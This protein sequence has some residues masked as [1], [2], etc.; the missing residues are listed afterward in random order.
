M[1]QKIRNT[2]NND[3]VYAG[4]NVPIIKQ[5][6]LKLLTISKNSI[7]ILILSKLIQQIKIKNTNAASTKPTM[8]HPLTTPEMAAIPPSM[9]IVNTMPRQNINLDKYL[10]IYIYTTDNT[11]DNENIN[12]IILQ[13]FIN[14]YFI[15]VKGLFSTTRLLGMLG[16]RIAD[17]VTR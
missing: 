15:T 2:I 12:K 14:S 1:N 6:F 10:T 7:P 8:I 3:N 11:N 13:N 17:P 4:I 5:S 16:L 9:I